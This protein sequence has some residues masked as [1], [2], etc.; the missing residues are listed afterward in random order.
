MKRKVAIYARVSTEHEAQLSS[1]E[2]QIQYYNNILSDHS[3][4]ELYDR[5]IDEGI[6]GTSIKKRKDFIRM[7]QDAEKGCFD[8]II[9]REVSRF[10]RNTVDTLQ[11]TRKLKRLGVEVYFKEDNIWTFKDDDGELKLTIMATLAQNESK[12][13]SQRVKAGQMIT[14]QNGVF[15]GN[16]NILGY[17]KVNK[18]MIINK[19]QAEIVKLIFKLY[20]EGK[21][22]SKI[23]YELERRSLKTAT[24]LKNWHPSVIV[25]ILQNPF[26]CGILVY[27]KSFVPDY[28]EQK[29]KKN[30]GEVEKVIVEGKHTPIISKDD[31]DKVQKILEEHSKKVK[32]GMTQIK[33]GSIAPKY[34]WTKKLECECGSKMNRRVFS[35]NNKENVIYSYHCCNQKNNGSAIKRMKEGLDPNGYCDIPQIQE[36]KLELMMNILINKILKDKEKVLKISEEIL[37][38]SIKSIN[39]D[40]SLSR[41]INSIILNQKYSND[42]LRKL[43]DGYVEGMIPQKI[44]LTKKSELEEEINKLE[45]RLNELKIKTEMPVSCVEDKIN[46]LKE[47]VLKKLNFDKNKVIDEIVDILIEK[48]IVH[49]NRFEWKLNCVGELVNFKNNNDLKKKTFFTRTI[50]T[51]DDVRNYNDKFHKLKKVLHKENIIMDIYI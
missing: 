39:I 41:E 35:N 51:E 17:D 38:E 3:D 36:W 10:A 33:I 2:N 26:Y 11:E 44:Y 8:L 12:K 16:G 40:E 13:I 45:E 28:L 20:L 19:E 49:K 22:S 32:K 9:T 24:G 15:Y 34:I 1:L 46:L 27:R 7:L 18:D 29:H 21:G 31:F 4:W 6:T 42:R 30:N 23:K 47:N 50:I 48:I 5:Y 37:L 14:F 43:V 25:H